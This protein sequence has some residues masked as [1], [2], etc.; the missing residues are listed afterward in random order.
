MAKKIWLISN[1]YGDLEQENQA[2]QNIMKWRFESITEEKFERIGFARDCI[3]IP[4]IGSR[5]QKYQLITPSGLILPYTKMVAKGCSILNHFDTILKSKYELADD[6]LIIYF[7]GDGQID[8]NQTIKIAEKLETCDF[9]LSDRSEN[10]GI[11]N[12][13]SLVEKFENS[14]IEDKFSIELSDV[15]CGCWGL[16][17]KHLKKI[18]KMLNSEGFEIELDL[19]ICSLEAGVAPLYVPIS[20]KP[21]VNSEFKANEDHLA[22]LL[23]LMKKFNISQ[24]TLIEKSMVFVRK[25]RELPNTY[26]K[27]FTYDVIHRVNKI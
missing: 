22:K 15:Q 6:D 11:S 20:V 14:F 21:A 23:Y 9:V 18:F 12:E 26:S 13:R 19:T 17:G 16:S 4:I 25:H 7:D 27:Y 1:V 10:L 8:Y 3:Q 5:T 24:T 2:M